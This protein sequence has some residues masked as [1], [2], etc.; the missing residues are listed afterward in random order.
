[1]DDPSDRVAVTAMHGQPRKGSAALNARRSGSF[2]VSGTVM[3]AVP[4][5]ITL[6]R[7]WSRVPVFETQFVGHCNGVG[8]WSF[9]SFERPSCLKRW[10]GPRH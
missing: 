2:A 6:R 10:P 3:M 5:T 8:F 1:M 4:S 9:E 7:V